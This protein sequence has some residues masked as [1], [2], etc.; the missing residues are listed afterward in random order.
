MLGVQVD[1]EHLDGGRMLS[2]SKTCSMCGAAKRIERFYLD[3]RAKDG[4]QSR[5]ADCHN[6]TVARSPKNIEIR[7]VLL[8]LGAA[9]AQEW[10]EVIFHALG[11]PTSPEPL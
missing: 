2:A 11:H 10:A 8:P 5:C 9:E 4:H 3:R 1:G 7:S 6:A